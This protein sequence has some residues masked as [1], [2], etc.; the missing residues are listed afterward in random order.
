M[1]GK[2]R[3][4][5]AYYTIIKLKGYWMLTVVIIITILISNKDFCPEELT[6]YQLFELTPTTQIEI[7]FYFLKSK[8]QRASLLVNYD[9][10]KP[11][12]KFSL[13]NTYQLS[14]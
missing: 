14:L 8:P 1:R 10:K 5:R 12:G 13:I 2:S 3:S 9:Y 11:R 4:W 7:R 6:T